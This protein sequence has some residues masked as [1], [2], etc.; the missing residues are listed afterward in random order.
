MPD[1]LRGAYPSANNG[2]TGSIAL[3]RRAQRSFD[4]DFYFAQTTYYDAGEVD[5]KSEPE[6]P[7][8]M[9]VEHRCM[10][11]PFALDFMLDM[12]IRDSEHRVPCWMTPRVVVDEKAAGRPVFGHQA[13]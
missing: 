12:P 11:E 4:D 8:C 7:R 5:E 9:S 10:A 2:S 3:G 13:Q 1:E 6:S